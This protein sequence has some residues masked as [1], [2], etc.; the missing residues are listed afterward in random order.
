MS[1]ARR[2][3]NKV[4]RAGIS[5][6]WLEGGNTGCKDT[7]LPAKTLQPRKYLRLVV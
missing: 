5:A 1:L 4:F 7:V 6:H 3:S 2:T